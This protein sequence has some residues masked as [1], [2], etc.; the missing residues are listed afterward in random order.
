MAGVKK[1]GLCC[2]SSSSFILEGLASN[3]GDE[4]PEPLCTF[5]LPPL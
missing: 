3:G 5:L 2:A 1:A 4:W